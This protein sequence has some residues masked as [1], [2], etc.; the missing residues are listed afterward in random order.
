MSTTMQAA[1]VRAF[2]QPLRIEEL[3]IPVPGQG[4][5]LVRVVASGVCHTDLHAADGDWPMKPALP[6]MP[7]HEVA[8]YVV[9]V[10]S[11]V[12]AFKEGD[13]VGVPWLHRACGICDY[14]L[15]GWETLSPAQQ[16]T[17]YTV[18]GTFADYVLA[19]A[20]FVAP[21]PN[22]LEF[23]HA[24]PILCAGV[25]TYKGLTMTEA[26]PGQWVVISGIGGLG[27]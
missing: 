13:R 24:A 2:K 21:L 1:V 25:T 19:E 8:G 11:G 7:G 17:G 22:S 5:V 10:G 27:H 16:D 6:C 14:C 18:N 23:I 12:T 15:S 20:A 3:P 9:A 26:R 4:Q